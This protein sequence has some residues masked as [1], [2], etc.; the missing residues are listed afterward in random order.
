MV[1]EGDQ[2]IGG[3]YHHPYAFFHRQSQLL[4][5]LAD[6]D[7]APVLERRSALHGRSV[8]HLPLD[9]P[10]TPRRNCNRSGNDD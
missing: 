9:E 4:A 2:D 7:P 5:D 3:V 10:P 8:S 1:V 6:I